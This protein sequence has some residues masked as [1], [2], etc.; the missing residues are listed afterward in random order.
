MK[1]YAIPLTGLLCLALSACPQPA[2]SPTVA[3]APPVVT[4]VTCPDGSDLLTHVQYVQLSVL[5]QSDSVQ[6]NSVHPNMDFTVAADL[7]PIDPAIQHDLAAA[8]AANPAFAKNALCPSST[9]PGGVTNPGLDGIFINRAQCV[10]PINPSDYDPSNCSSMSDTDIAANSWGLRTPL[11]TSKTYIAI[12][13]GLW[14]CPSGRGYCAPPFAQFYQ[15]LVKALFDKT[16]CGS[17]KPPCNAADINRPVFQS[18][19]DTSGLSVLATLAHERGHI[20]WWEQFVQPPGST[21]YT[22]TL[23]SKAAAFCRGVIYPGGN[24]QGVPVRLPEYRYVEFGQL[25]QNSPVRDLPALLNSNPAGAAALVDGIYSR[26]QYPSVLAAYSL[27]EEF[28]EAFQWSV[29]RNAGLAEFTANI[30]GTSRPILHLGHASD[31]GAE[32][33]L[34]CFDDLS[35]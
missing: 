17:Q 23:I 21:P 15:R 16:A 20:W 35:R 9:T 18:S 1:R 6:P 7:T 22:P 24:W 14:R 13:L 30:T 11:P 34:R 28:V 10:N 25:S 27:D 5:P 29:L 19:T 3:P 31:G 4:S 8:F 33:K 12:S 32:A 2:P 26:G